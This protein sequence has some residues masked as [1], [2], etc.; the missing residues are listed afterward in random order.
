MNELFVLPGVITYIVTYMLPVCVLAQTLVI[1]MCYSRYPHDRMKISETSAE[2]LILVYIIFSAIL[3]EQAEE[4]YRDGILSPPIY[5]GLRIVFFIIVTYVVTAVTV[6]TRKPN[7]LPIILAAGLT[8]PFIEVITGYAFVYL[9]TV[10]IIFWLIRSVMAGLSYYKE[11]KNGLSVLSIKNAIDFM[12]TGVMFCLRDGFILLSNKRMSELM[13]TITGK[14]Q[15]NGKYFTGLLTSGE[16]KEG[17]K[18]TW[19]EGQ[20]VCLLPDDSVWMFKMTQ[21]HVKRREYIQITASDITERWRL[22]EK[23]EKQSEELSKRRDDLNETLANIDTV[24]RERAIQI[25]KMRAHDVLGERLTAMLRIVRNEKLPDHTVLRDQSQE[26]IDELNS[27]KN[28]L[29]PQDELNVLI[30]TFA[31]IGV[32]VILSGDSEN[33]AASESNAVEAVREAVI[34]AVRNN[35]VSKVFVMIAG[36]GDEVKV[37][38]ACDGYDG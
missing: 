1:A 7:T 11:N 33:N 38:T 30:Q 10:L 12:T 4:G 29:S 32:E 21:L 14:K 24:S 17:C 22:T 16:V 28:K 20:N 36:S 3:Y 19:F 6:Y 18:I 13:K 25:S 27:S 35:F 37:S 5:V 8:L 23:L 9:I 26:L 15:R 34:N 2:I 31:S